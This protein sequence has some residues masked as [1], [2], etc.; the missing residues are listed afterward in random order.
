MYHIGAVY[1][2]Y[3]SRRRVF[4]DSK[5]SRKDQVAKNNRQRRNRMAQKNVS[6]KKNIC[7][8][9]YMHAYI[10]N[11]HI[12]VC[13]KK[14]VYQTRC[15]SKEVARDLILLHDGRKWRREYG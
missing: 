14:Q 11:I 13:K 15:G 12:V 2:Y 8:F 5:P 3:E 6:S 9:L 10:P 1:R 7:I 4:N